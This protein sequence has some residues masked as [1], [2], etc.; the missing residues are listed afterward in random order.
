MTVHLKEPEKGK[1]SCFLVFF[2]PPHWLDHYICKAIFVK[3]VPADFEVLFLLLLHCLKV[4]FTPFHLEKRSLFRFSRH[5]V[6]LKVGLI[7]IT[8]L[9]V[10]RH[11]FSEIV[12]WRFNLSIYIS[13]LWEFT[14][15]GVF[16][17]EIGATGEANLRTEKYFTRY[18][19]SPN[20]FW[21][22]ELE[23]HV[24]LLEGFRNFFEQ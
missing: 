14:Y 17:P 23:I 5:S 3:D 19:F 22:Q 4:L 2:S 8:S 9:N 6:E 10:G 21:K 13:F 7:C 16:C 20:Q 12:P 15:P 24:N 1:Y 18:F 11:H